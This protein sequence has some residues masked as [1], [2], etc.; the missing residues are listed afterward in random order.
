MPRSP[1]PPRPF[2]RQP[3]SESTG[4]SRQYF[5]LTYTRTARPPDNDLQATHAIETPSV[6]WPETAARCQKSR[7]PPC[8]CV[9][10][11]LHRCGLNRQSH[12]THHSVNN[13]T[14]CTRRCPQLQRQRSHNT[15][16]EPPSPLRERHRGRRDK[17]T[18]HARKLCFQRRRA[19]R[20][21]LRGFSE[22]SATAL[23]CNC[24]G[25]S[26]QQWVHTCRPT[27]AHL[28]NRAMLR[29]EH[30]TCLS[31]SIHR[32]R[33]TSARQSSPRCRIQQARGGHWSC[34]SGKAVHA[35]QRLWR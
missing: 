4:P 2:R 26:I 30:N 25:A 15:S 21:R 16:D 31:C 11:G 28:Y 33:H 27:F 8:P 23:A 17:A 24:S 18:P 7:S 5:S 34:F 19:L 12:P 3:P 32:T 13:S 6:P 29:A 14:G 35:S 1:L 20:Q 10:A 9:I 22:D